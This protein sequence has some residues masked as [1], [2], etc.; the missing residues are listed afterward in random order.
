V[1]TTVDTF[2]QCRLHAGVNTPR[3]CGREANQVLTV[4]RNLPDSALATQPQ[5]RWQVMDH[6]LDALQ[7]SGLL[8]PSG[9]AIDS[10]SGQVCTSGD[11]MRQWRAVFLR[12]RSQ[13]KTAR[14]C[15]RA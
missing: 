3:A 13:P 10:N 6:V 15:A 1:G 8:P 11:A 7:S 9:A 2:A 14:I 4:P 5:E 12:E